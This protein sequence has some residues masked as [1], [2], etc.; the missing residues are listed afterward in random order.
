ME[1]Y[2]MDKGNISDG[3]HTFDELYYHRMILFA[4]ICNQNKNV[5]WKSR[6]HDDGTMFENY[7]IVGVSTPK[8]QFTY[9][10]HLDHWDLFEI[11]DIPKAQKWDGHTAKDVDRLL[12][13]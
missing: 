9:H 10:Y 11:K 13:L 1:D 2:R 8:G 12:S 6:L 4:V 3:Y 5:A 7:F